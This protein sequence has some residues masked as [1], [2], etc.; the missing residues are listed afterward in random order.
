MSRA[1][2]QTNTT[3]DGVAVDVRACLAEIDVLIRSTWSS[4]IRLEFHVASDLPAVKCDQLD[5]QSAI[6]N[7]AFNARDAMPDGGIVSIV[8]GISPA[9]A[10]TQIEVRITDNGLGMTRETLARAFDPFFTTKTDGLGGL[11]LPM[12]QRFAQEAGGR[13]EIESTLGVGTTAALQLPVATSRWEPRTQ[14]PPL[15]SPEI[16]MLPLQ[17]LLP[18]APPR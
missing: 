5:L 4:N 9:H 12:V 17:P 10:A 2:G 1:G 3:I 18:G 14:H 13:V 6:M 11:G 7:L 8:A 16:G 15:F